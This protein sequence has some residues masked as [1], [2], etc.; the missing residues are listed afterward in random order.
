MSYKLK[1]A[2]IFV[3]A[4]IVTGCGSAPQTN[5]VNVD[6]GAQAWTGSRFIDGNGD[7]TAYT[8][9]A[10]QTALYIGGSNLDDLGISSPF[11]AKFD[12][13][14]NLSWNL[15]SLF[16]STEVVRKLAI[17]NQNNAYV[18]TKGVLLLPTP[19]A[20]NGG[21]IRYYLSKVSPNGKLVWRKVAH[22]VGVTD[23]DTVDYSVFALDIDWENTLYLSIADGWFATFT[24]DGNLIDSFTIPPRLGQRTLKDARA[25]QVTG[26]KEW[27][28]IMGWDVERRAIDGT[29]IATKEYYPRGNFSGMKI[30]SVTTLP[31]RLVFS[32]PT[33]LGRLNELCISAVERTCEHRQVGTFDALA[34]NPVLSDFTVVTQDATTPNLY[35]IHSYRVNTS[36]SRL[37]Q[38]RGAFSG[39]TM[40]GNTIVSLNSGSSIF[41]IDNV[42]NL[43]S[44]TSGADIRVRKFNSI[45][46]QY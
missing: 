26:I 18:V 42:N 15:Q 14:G 1:H 8:A 36:S 33:K 41:L 7:I 5:A 10:N 29:L 45:G 23:V 28:I 21:R 16:P 25:R 40:P 13:S 38:L 22:V 31:V 3:F 46:V 44:T 24:P 35:R 12:A 30:A 27:L 34:L 43:V 4:F 11:L 37:I 32:R 17:D 9:Q 39:N 19:N 6:F 20:P 2:I